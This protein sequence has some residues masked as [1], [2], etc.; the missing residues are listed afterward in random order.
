[1]NVPLIDVALQ[2]VPLKDDLEA[3]FSRVLSSGG[4]ILGPELAALED[5]WPP[6]SE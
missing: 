5:S 3:A 6:T 2:N 4:F 1:M